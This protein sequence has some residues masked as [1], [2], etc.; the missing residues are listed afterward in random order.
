MLPRESGISPIWHPLLGGTKLARAGEVVGAIA[1]DVARYIDSPESIAGLH[2][3]GD[4]A[5]LAGGDAGLVLFLAALARYEDSP[6]DAAALRDKVLQRA[7]DA[8]AAR[9]LD[10][11][12]FSGFPGVAWVVQRFLPAPKSD[13]GDAL[14]AIDDVLADHLGRGNSRELDL[15]SGLVGIGVYLLD[16]L[17]RPAAVV[18]LQAIVRTLAERA[19]PDGSGGVAWRVPPEE[20]DEDD[21]S[22]YP[23]GRFDLGVAHGVPGIMAFLARA[24]AAG[25][26]RERTSALVDACFA[27]LL[28]QER[29]GQGVSAFP[30]WIATIG[31]AKNTEFAW[32][33]GDL[34]VSLAV[35]TTATAAGRADWRDQA[36]RIG[37]AV[38][39]RAMQ[40]PPRA[41]AG[42]CHGNCG[43]A[44]QFNRLY[45]ATGQSLFRDAARRWYDH[46]FS[47]CQAGKGIGGFLSLIRDENLQD[48]WITTPELLNGAAGI[49]LGLLAGMLPIEPD[50]DRILLISP[51]R[52]SC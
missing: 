46:T 9:A 45:Q 19:D 34:G 50:W 4:P 16:R 5:G 17:P 24:A 3:T 1:I 52:A 48:V 33:Y 44:H 7:V 13:G 25:I 30:Y 39:R 51:L 49:G 35:L 47:S 11:S 38:A 28:R 43:V 20:L 15:I 22:Q 8:L 42:L 41:D 27:W 21:R 37:L 40:A 36:I 6:I 18:G 10:S 31:P 14:A 32:C 23:D 2:R 26:D 12:L 29:I